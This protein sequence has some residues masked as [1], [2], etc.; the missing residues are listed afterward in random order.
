MT[1]YTTTALEDWV[2]NF[3][4]QL[5]MVQPRQIKEDL[6]IRHFRIYLHRKPRPAFHEVIGNYLGITVDSR[7]IKEIQRE[8]FFHELCHLLRH[9]G[10]QGMMPEAFRELQ[11]WDARRFTLCAAIPYHMLSFI[12]FEQ[13]NVVA[14]TAAIYKVTEELAEERLEQIKRRMGLFTSR[15]YC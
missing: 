13:D 1:K 11:E 10:I 9:S 12:D 14:E 4:R 15:I 5:G 3:Y 7:E 6:I 8:M 2:T